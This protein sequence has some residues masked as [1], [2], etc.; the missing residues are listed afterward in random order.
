[1]AETANIL[2]WRDVTIPAEGYERIGLRGVNLAL[3][4][5]V[6]AL[7]RL[8]QGRER[9]PLGDAAQGLI[10]PQS[11]EVLFNGRSWSRMRASRQ[12]VCRGRIGRVF[13]EGGWMS[14]LDVA[15]NVTL[16]QRHHTRRRGAD[17]LR[18]ANGLAQSFGLREIPELRPRLLHRWDLRRAAWVRAF[19]GAPLLVILEQPM[20]NAPPQADEALIEAANRACARGAAVLWTTASTPI[21]KSTTLYG[22]RRYVMQGEAL[23][24]APENEV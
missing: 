23:L 14:N 22:V 1:M 13:D 20:Q 17:I 15:E 8:E 7:V 18:E 16:S 6:P 12:S 9:T 5:G 21:W 10:T 3:A 19:L 11:G 2:E 4:P 24:P